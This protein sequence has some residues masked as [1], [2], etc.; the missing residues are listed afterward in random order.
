MVSTEE[1]VLPHHSRYVFSVFAVTHVAFCL[2]LIS[3]QS[4]DLRILHAAPAVI[5]LETFLFS[6]YPVLLWTL[7]RSHFGDSFSKY[8]LRRRPWGFSGLLGHRGLQPCF[9]PS[10]EVGLQQQLLLL[11]API[12]KR[13]NK[14]IENANP[15]PP[16]FDCYCSNEVPEVKYFTTIFFRF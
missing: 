16:V 5:Q 3:V 15:I 1:L 9:H 8:E 12:N 10:E 4:A 6:F 2:S 14:H 11:V 13:T 7:R